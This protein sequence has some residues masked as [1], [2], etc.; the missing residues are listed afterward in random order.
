M[1]NVLEKKRKKEGIFTEKFIKNFREIFRPLSRALANSSISPNSITFLSLF[2]G[3]A[4]GVF[5]ALDYLWTGLILGLMMGFCDII[6]GQMAKDYNGATKFGGILDSTI[7]R[8]CEF[9]AYTGLGIRYYFQDRPVWVLLC[10]MV[11][12]GSVMVSYVKARAEGENLECKVGWLQRPERLAITATGVLFRGTGIDIAVVF[13]A[14]FTQ[15]TVIQR[16]IHIY[17]LT[18]QN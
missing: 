5:L 15:W 1:E 18:K 11:F 16:L 2:L 8:F 14:V 7:D 12:L 4:C 3:L 9:F 6:D 17:K 10:A 13:L